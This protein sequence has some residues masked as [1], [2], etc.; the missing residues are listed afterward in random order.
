MLSPLLPGLLYGA[1]EVFVSLALRSKQRTDA[2]QGSLKLLW[3]VIGISMLLAVLAYYCF[4]GASFAQGDGLYWIGI[5]VLIGGVLLRAYAILYLGKF[6]TVDVSIAADQTVVDSGPY[7]FI[8]H[9]SYTGSL[10]AFAGI[11]LCMANVLATIFV[12]APVTAAF[13]YR[14]RI[15]ETALL[16]GLGEPY[17]QY[18]QRTKRLVPG[19]Y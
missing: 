10:L 18:S 6:F 7:R 5:A 14:I 2:D 4:P 8:R 12:L 1:S 13:L 17:R 16:A 3:R 19:I 11:A 9:P 15:E